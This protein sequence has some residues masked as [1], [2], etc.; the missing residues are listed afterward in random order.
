MF[1]SSM[2]VFVF[3]LRAPTADAPPPRGHTA[4]GYDDARG[5]VVL[6]G[7]LVFKGA[8]GEGM[9]F[10]NDQWTW[11]GRSWQQVA[12][13]GPRMA[14]QA[15]VYDAKHRRLLEFGG[16]LGGE[17]ESGDLYAVS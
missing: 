4:L 11:D 16:W 9:T 2:L 13:T 3:V 10:L 12:S 6:S 7:G 1:A 14:G 15:L 17:N 8:G 5:R